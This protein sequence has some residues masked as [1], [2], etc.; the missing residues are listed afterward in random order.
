M[1]QEKIPTIII[2]GAVLG[3]L[4]LYHALIKNKDKKEFNVKIFERKTSP[5]NRWQD[6]IGLFNYGVRSLLNCVLSS[7]T[8]NLPKA[9]PNPIPDV[10]TYGITI[11]DQIGNVLLTPPTKPFKD[12]YEIAKISHDDS[13]KFCN[14]LVGADGINSPIRKQ[15]L[16]ELQIIDYGITHVSAD[17]SVPQHLIDKANKIYGNFF[18]QNDEKSEPHY[19]VTLVY[20]YPSKLDNVDVESDK[21][22]VDDNDPASVIEHVKRLIRTLRSDCDAVHVMNPIL[23]LGA[24]NA[25]QDADKLSQ[26]L[27]KYTDSNISFIEEYEKEMLKRTSADVLK[28]ELPHLRLLFHLDLLAL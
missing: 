4:S 17:V 23:G 19:R 18:E 25:I 3:G 11:T 5:T 24:N 6:H 9:I 27:L 8:S 22:K 16:P 28:L 7:I 1:Q 21:V 15:K 10:E 26:A 12:V 20:S 2:V 13:Q 14:I